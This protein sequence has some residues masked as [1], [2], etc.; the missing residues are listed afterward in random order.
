MDKVSEDKRQADLTRKYGTVEQK[1]SFLKEDFLANLRILSSKPSSA[2]AVVSV[3]IAFSCAQEDVKYALFLEAAILD[4]SPGLN[5]QSSFKSD[6]ERRTLMESARM[7]V[8]F[9]SPSYLDS[10]EQIEEF[11]IALCRERTSP[12]RVLFPITLH[13]LPQKPTYIHIV[14]TLMNT[15]DAMWAELASPWNNQDPVIL[16][17]I[18]S[19]E[20]VTLRAEMVLGLHEAACIITETLTSETNRYWIKDSPAPPSQPMNH[21]TL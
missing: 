20:E 18:G 9:L 12:T 8:A 21:N 3:D 15:N 16:N 4:A 11:H 7:I 1:L 6:S 13:P 10:P 5:V 19:G 17:T 14:P 2:D